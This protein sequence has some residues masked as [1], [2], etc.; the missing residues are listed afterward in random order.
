MPLRARPA[1]GCGAPPGDVRVQ[2]LTRGAA[3]AGVSQGHSAPSEHRELRPVTW[4]AESERWVQVGALWGL[5]PSSHG[6]QVHG[7]GRVA[8]LVPGAWLGGRA[9]ALP[10]HLHGGEE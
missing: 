1:E 8:A 6:R 7:V 4:A 9:W 10:I 2:L 3:E 5:L